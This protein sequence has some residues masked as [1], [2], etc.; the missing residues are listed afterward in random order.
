MNIETIALNDPGDKYYFITYQT[1]KIN[2]KITWG[3]NKDKAPAEIE[4]LYADL[5]NLIM[6]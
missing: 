6:E 3:G 4:A 5:K 1:S 2:H